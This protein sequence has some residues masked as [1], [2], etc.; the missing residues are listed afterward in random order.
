MSESIIGEYIPCKRCGELFE[1]RGWNHQYC[2]SCKN[3]HHN[4]RA[5]RSYYAKHGGRR[6]RQG[7]NWSDYNRFKFYME[8][9]WQSAICPRCGAHM[10]NDPCSSDQ[11][12]NPLRITSVD[13]WHW[14]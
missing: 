13:T 14:T 11:V 3:I 10:S 7:N 12:Q 1:K 4:E 6:P 8:K 5:M 9:T 2:P